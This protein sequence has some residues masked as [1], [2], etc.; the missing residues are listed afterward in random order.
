MRIAGTTTLFGVIGSPVAH[1][2]SPLMHNAA[3]EY[4]GL[5]H[6]YV[7]MELKPDL[8]SEGIGGLRALG[9]RGFNVTIPHKES[10]IG[11]LDEIDREAQII[12]AVNTVVNRNGKLLGYNTDGRGF[13]RSLEEQ[14]NFDP[15]GQRVVVLGAGGAARAIVCGLACGGAGRI[16][17]GNRN[18]QRGMGL[19]AAIEKHYPCEIEVV[20]LAPGALDRALADCALVVQTSP[21]GMYGEPETTIIDPGR[22]TGGTYV[23]DIIFN[24]RET[25]FLRGAKSRGCSTANGLGMLLY[26]GA[27]AFELWTGIQAPVEV[28]HQALQAKGL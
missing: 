2:F 17:I 3:F 28:M 9:F 4:L 26:Q 6:C 7:A 19:K 5:D 16:T 18:V 27:V 11:Y 21:V 14:W 13:L 1:S 20:D 23:Y 22:L 8:L 15:R 12:G 10:I 25:A 24:P